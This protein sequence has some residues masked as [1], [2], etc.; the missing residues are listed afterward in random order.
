MTL[1][2]RNACRP[3]CT[4]E[5]RT[6]RNAAGIVGFVRPSPFTISEPV[7][8][9]AP[10]LRPTKSSRMQAPPPAMLAWL[11]TCTKLPITVPRPPWMH[12]NSLTMTWLP[13]RMRSEAMKAQWGWSVTGCPTAASTSRSP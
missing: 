4:N 5:R 7:M 3:R 13:R 6:A 8:S 11:A 2:A 9:R 1:V 10:V 12:E